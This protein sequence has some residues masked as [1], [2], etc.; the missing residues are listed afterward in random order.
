MTAIS[1]GQIERAL[2]P[3]RVASS[4]QLAKRIRIYIELLLRWNRSISL[5]TVTDIDEILRFHFG[6]SLFALPM[7]PVQKSRLADVGSGAGFPGLPLAIA[8]QELQ[9]TLIES[10]ARKFAFLNEVIRSLGLLNAIALR[11]RMEDIKKIETGLDVV[12]SRAL[13]Q[14][15]SLLRW[16]RVHLRSNGRIV[17]WIGEHDAQR[18]SS[19]GGFIWRPPI[20][21]PDS[22]HRVILIGSPIDQ[23][24]TG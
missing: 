4:S 19:D 11:N 7:I 1:Q 13:G 10:D 14:F 15:D 22:M 12:T 16:S 9:V 23:S 17:F 8:S 24:P 2:K 6:E 3:Y 21:I 20:A 5:T 18:I